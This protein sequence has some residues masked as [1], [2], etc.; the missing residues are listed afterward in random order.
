MTINRKKIF[1]WIKIAIIVYCSI[2][3]ALYYLQ[4]KF[5]F[6]P[7][8]LPASHAY[9]FSTPFEELN[10]ALNKTDT[11]N[12]I[13]FT[14][15]G[16]REGA[17]VYYHGNRDNVEHYAKYVTYFV[18]KGYE[19]WMPDYPGY[20]KSSGPRTEKK[21]YELAWQVQALV[22]TRFQDDS[23]L[24]YG[25]SLGTGVAAYAATVW[26][27]RAVILETPYYS[28][29]DLFSQYAFIYPTAIMSNYKIPTWK[30]LA[31]VAAP[32]SIFH[33]TDDGVIPLRCANKLKRV[34]KSRD[35]FFTIPGGEHN[36]LPTSEIYKQA[37]DSILR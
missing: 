21:L 31:D 23:I 19:V 13:R 26:P 27:C 20:G 7:T 22:R 33:G 35:R 11:I 14:P 10:I 1:S 5:I 4:E 12:L 32:I 15:K 25:K 2:G 28:I 16:T 17:I 9:K 37:M 3:I 30:Y 8:P 36:N 34:L 18:E 29:T 6:H 24:I